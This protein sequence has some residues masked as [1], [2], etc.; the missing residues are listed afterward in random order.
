MR[1]R[2]KASRSGP[3]RAAHLFGLRAESIA[4]LLLRL[5]GY[6]VLARRF[7]VSGGEIDLVVLRGDTIAFVEV[8]ARGD[9]DLAAASIGPIKRQ[10]IARAARAWLARNP[11]AAGFTLRGD[12][13]YVAPRRLPRHAPSAYRLQID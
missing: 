8:K 7:A 6:R 4:A 5:K 11:W 3:R 10:R 13:V 2:P 12:A 1:E 9:L